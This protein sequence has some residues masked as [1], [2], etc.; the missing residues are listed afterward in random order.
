MTQTRTQ[1]AKGG[2]QCGAVR[3]ALFVP[4]EKPHACHCRMCQR[5]VGGLFAALA[6]A[7]KPDFAWTKGAAKYFASSNMAKR[8]FCGDCGTPLSY[9]FNRAE[10][11]VYVT[12]G[13]MDHPER[14]PIQRQVGIESRVPWV[15]FCEDIPGSETAADWDQRDAYFANM[16]SNQT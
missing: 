1:V 6:G 12:I 4:P 9:E 15:K 14:V 11:R 16:K 7:R 5:A 8:G 10:S 2:C 13:S 3:Y